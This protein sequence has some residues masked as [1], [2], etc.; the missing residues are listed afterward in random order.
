MLLFCRLGENTLH[1]LMDLTVTF[2]CRTSGAAVARASGDFHCAHNVS[3]LLRTSPRTS[4]R[5]L[6]QRGLLLAD[7]LGHNDRFVRLFQS[8]PEGASHGVHAR[9]Q[10]ERTRHYYST[11]AGLGVEAWRAQGESPVPTRRQGL[12]LAHISVRRPKLQDHLGRVG[13]TTDAPCPSAWWSVL[14]HRRVSHQ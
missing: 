1:K 9:P 10:P 8:A 7:L 13:D 11:P 2:S 5:L 12:F 6:R 4:E 3:F 14:H